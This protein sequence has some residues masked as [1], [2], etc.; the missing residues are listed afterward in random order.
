MMRRAAR[1][2]LYLGTVAIVL[3]LAK[4]H[5]RY[6]G[7]YVLHS[8]EPARLVWTLAYLGLLILASYGA[9]LPEL[10]ADA[11]P[12]GHVG[13]RRAGRGGAGHLRR[14]TAGGRRVAAAVRRARFGAAVGPVES[15]VR[16]VRARRAA[17][18]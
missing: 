7:H 8:T 16:R 5:A 1:P 3:G 2:L 13:G 12:G 18:R 9:G 4:F 11:A 15:A 10:P 17:A 6:I 14:P